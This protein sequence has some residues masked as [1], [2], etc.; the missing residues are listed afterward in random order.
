MRPS[1]S[2]PTLAWWR[3]ARSCD[4]EMKCSLRSSVNLT[5]WSIGDGGPGGEDVLGPGMDH[6]GPEAATDVDGRHVDLFVREIEDVGQGEANTGRGL[7]GV[8]DPQP[9]VVAVP[10]GVAGPTLEGA[11]HAALHVEVEFEDVGGGGQAAST[12]PTCSW[13]W[14]ATL[15]GHVVVDQLGPERSVDTDHRRQRLVVDDHQFRRVL[16]DVAVGGHARRRSPGRRDGL[17]R[18]PARPGSEE[19]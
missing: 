3:W 16:T 6:L 17:G 15:L 9:T 8:L 18:G 7:G 14:A 5:S 12:S 1:S 4:D 19:R 2:K 13:W 10:A 11:P